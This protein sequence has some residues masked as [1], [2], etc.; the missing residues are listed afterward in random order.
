VSECV[1]GILGRA[2]EGRRVQS[3]KRT[4]GQVKAV[5]QL[6]AIDLGQP[7]FGIRNRDDYNPCRAPIGGLVV[8]T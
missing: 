8:V 4:G 2:G 7:E 6:T 3:L 1:P 5:W